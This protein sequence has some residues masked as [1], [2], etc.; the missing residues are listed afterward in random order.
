MRIACN[1][2]KKQTLDNILKRM[3]ECIIIT[4]YIEGSIRDILEKDGSAV[5]R[6]RDR[7]DNRIANAFV[8]CADAGYDKARQESIRPD[9]LMGDFDSLETELPGDIKTITFPA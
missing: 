3:R 8:I 5:K 1:L 7:A 6:A 9:I 4:A 2:L